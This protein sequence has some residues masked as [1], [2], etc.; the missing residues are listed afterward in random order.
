MAIMAAGC[1]KTE[2]QN[3]VQTPIGFSTEVGK[4]TKAIVTP[5]DNEKEIDRDL[6]DKT[7]IIY[8]SSKGIKKV[9]KNVKY[10]MM[11]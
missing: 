9:L 1:Q 2:I 8:K 3:E 4:Q 11:K 10:T 7:K 6:V 5:V